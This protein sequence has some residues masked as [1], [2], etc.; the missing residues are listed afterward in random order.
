MTSR[1]SLKP[2]AARLTLATAALMGA[3]WLAERASAEN[4]PV[5]YRAY[6]DTA[7][8]VP[9]GTATGSIPTL[10]ASLVISPGSHTFG[11][12]AYELRKQGLY[13]FCYPFQENQQR[14]VFDRSNGDIEALLSSLAWIVSH[15]NSDNPK[16]PDVLTR[17]ATTSKLFLTC[18]HTSQWA[19]SILRDLKIQ[20]RPVDTITLDAWNKYDDGHSMIEVRRDDLGK[21]ILYDLDENAYFLHKTTPL[22]LV[23]MIAHAASGDYE[24]KLLATDAPLDVSNFKSPKNGFDWALCTELTRTKQG[25]RNW[26]KRVLQVPVIDHC[27]FLASPNRTDRARIE[28]YEGSHY[29]CLT[30]AEFL[31]RFY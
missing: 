6:L 15:G 27:F 14:I 17:K 12:H 26:Y 3:I 28:H 13:R 18:S 2:L 22:S 16:S 1:P 31:K 10:P 24:I 23:E 4:A 25:L 21:W 30:R 20:A 9:A 19:L 11:G 8:S 5:V 29:N 7:E